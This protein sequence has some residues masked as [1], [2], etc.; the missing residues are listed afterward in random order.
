MRILRIVG[1]VV[2]ASAASMCLYLAVTCAQ[3]NVEHEELTDAVQQNASGSFVLL[4]DGFTHYELAGPENGRT[5]V[6]IHGFSVPYYLWDQTFE[7]MV[8]A[9]FRVLRYDLYGRGLSDRP[10]VHYN[11]DLYDRQLSDLIAALHLQTPVDV[12]GASMGG[13]VAVTF[14]V[15]HPEKVRALALFDPGHFT[16]EPMPWQISTPI[17]GEYTAC[18]RLV[19]SLP[20]GQKAD[21][22]HPERYPDYFAKYAEQMR[23]KGF[24]RALL[25]TI[26]DYFI[27]DVRPDFRRVGASH[28]PVMLVWGQLDKDVPFEV[29]KEVLAEIPQAEFHPLAD[30][31]H[32]GFYESPEVVNPMLIEFLNRN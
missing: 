28:K 31:A 21:F 4:S 13:P 27:T 19:P 29:S 5:V 22:I 10:H 20:D 3:H 26:R 17:V 30:A 18:V 12:V 15:R 25:S 8:K 11:A 6:L 14:A 23:Y 24:R 2:L 16:G 32:V 1:V 9:G 7:P